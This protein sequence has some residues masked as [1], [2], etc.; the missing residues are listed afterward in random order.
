[1]S[2]SKRKIEFQCKKRLFELIA[3]DFMC[4]SCHMVPRSG[5]VFQSS[6]RNTLCSS[7][8]NPTHENFQEVFGFE[9]LL[10]ELPNSCMFKKNNCQ[11]VLEPENLDYHEEECE[12][13]DVNCPLGYCQESIPAREL[14]KHL[15]SDHDDP[16][17]DASSFDNV[18]MLARI[19]I[20]EDELDQDVAW[21]AFVKNDKNLIL[22]QV[23][24]DASLKLLLIWLQ[25]F[26]TK[27][28]TKNYDC[29]IKVGC[30]V[31][32]NHPPHSLDDNK[33]TIY[34]SRDGLVVPIL[35]KNIHDNSMIIECRIMDMKSEKV[36]TK[37]KLV[38]KEIILQMQTQGPKVYRGED[39][40]HINRFKEIKEKLKNNG[41]WFH[42]SGSIDA[43]Q[44]MTDRDVI[45]GGF[46]LFGNPNGCS[47]KIKL[48]EIGIGSHEDNVKPLAESDE[49]T[50]A[51][52]PKNTIPILFREPLKIK[53][54][55]WC[56]TTITTTALV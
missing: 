10:K 36:E 42:N 24:L 26:G 31:H 15:K 1:M 55:R 11:V 6:D 30:L 19:Q 25:I 51:C 37:Q 47:G 49:I 44:F 35:K 53:G 43:I 38:E 40:L 32:E 2:E 22:L 23:R 16:A 50:Y 56:V 34:Q 45:I 48:F 29:T 41:T 5:P 28:E 46:S 33:Q 27:F 52:E 18:K 12:F 3:E 21:G 4:V 8:K 7:C 9:K 14:N 39:Y 13:R 54:H 20:N 17:K